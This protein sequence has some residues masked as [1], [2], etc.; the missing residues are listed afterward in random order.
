MTGLCPMLSVGVLI[1]HYIHALS[2]PRALLTFL[3]TLLVEFGSKENV[4]LISKL[5]MMN[6]YVMEHNELGWFRSS[7][8]TLELRTP[9][10]L[11]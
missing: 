3:V 1:K 4:F 11:L 10:H 6:T 7:P 5:G 2:C 8:M 9:L